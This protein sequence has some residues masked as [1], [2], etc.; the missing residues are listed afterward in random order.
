MNKHGTSFKNAPRSSAAGGT[1]S[2]NRRKNAS[3]RRNKKSTSL[4]RRVP[5]WLIIAGILGAIAVYIFVLITFFV[6]PFSFRWD[7]IYG[8]GVNP[9]GFEVRGIDISRYQDNIDWTRLRNAN[10]NGQPI[11]FAFIKATGDSVELTTGWNVLATIPSGYRPAGDVYGFGM[12]RTL[13]SQCE[14]SVWT[15]GYVRIYSSAATTG[16]ARLSL[17]FLIG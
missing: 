4:L 12:S 2:K 14:T 6:D 7:A 1:S 9:D 15:N 8:K 5:I 10:I 13:S 17:V 3:R 16:I 11:S